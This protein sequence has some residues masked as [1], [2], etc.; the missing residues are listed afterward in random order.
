MYQKI[1]RFLRNYMVD[2]RR[3]SHIILYM[4]GKVSACSVCYVERWSKGGGEALL[5]SSEV[6]AKVSEIYVAYLL[7]YVL[8]Y[9]M[10]C[11]IRLR[12]TI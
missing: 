10:L 9:E 6:Y 3:P 8:H 12:I 5:D 7:E 1:K 11:P 4:L 2:F